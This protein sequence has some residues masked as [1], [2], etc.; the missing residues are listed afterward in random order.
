MLRS[1]VFIPVVL[2]DSRHVGN[3]FIFRVRQLVKQN[4]ALAMGWRLF[5][6]TPGMLKDGSA[7]DNL[8]ALLLAPVT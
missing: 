3:E 8:R 4:T 6:Y 1:P 2:I 5:R 7:I